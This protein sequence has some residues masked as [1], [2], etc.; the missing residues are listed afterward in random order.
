MVFGAWW[1][2]CKIICLP[3]QLFD[4]FMTGGQASISSS[5]LVMGAGM[6]RRWD[7][8]IVTLLFSLVFLGPPPSEASEA[9]G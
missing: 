7:E 6:R 9:A 5:T 1:H 3:L 8:A 2:W 4:G